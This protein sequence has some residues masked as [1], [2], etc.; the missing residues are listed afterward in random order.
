M[1]LPPRYSLSGS[2]RREVED[3]T[4]MFWVHFLQMIECKLINIATLHGYS[5]NYA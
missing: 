5:Y 1:K 3:E 4:V 2:N